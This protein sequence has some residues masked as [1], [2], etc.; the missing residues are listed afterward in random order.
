MRAR[1]FVRRRGC[2]ATAGFHLTSLHSP[3]STTTT[4]GGFTMVED[5]AS[6]WVALLRATARC[7]LLHKV[8]TRIEKSSIVAT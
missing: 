3:S 4:L 2:S 5:M 7:M 6:H 8:L 1:A